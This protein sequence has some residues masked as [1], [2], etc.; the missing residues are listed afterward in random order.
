MTAPPFCRHSDYK[1]V[2]TIAMPVEN[3]ERGDIIARCTLQ[4]SLPHVWP[5]ILRPL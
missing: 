1:I 4:G 3:D 2:G 5:Q